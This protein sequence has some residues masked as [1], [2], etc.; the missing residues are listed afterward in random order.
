MK[1][2]DHK[3]GEMGKEAR[4]IL[5]LRGTCRNKLALKQGQESWEKGSRGL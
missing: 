3:Q 2:T 4:T 1:E 5:G